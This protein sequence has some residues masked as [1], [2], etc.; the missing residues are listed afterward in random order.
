MWPFPPRQKA[1]PA[2]FETVTATNPGGAAVNWLV[3]KSAPGGAGCGCGNAGVAT[4]VTSGGGATRWVRGE[5]SRGSSRAAASPGGAFPGPRG[6]G[7][8]GDGVRRQRL[9][10]RSAPGG[11][12]AGAVAIGEAP[13]LSSA[14]NT[15]FTYGAA[16]T[17]TVAA[18][19]VP[20]PSLSAAGALPSGLTFTDNGDG[21]GTLG[22]T[23]SAAGSFP[24][25]ITAH[26]GY[27]ADATQSFTLTV[28]AAST[29]TA[30]TS[31]VNPSVFGQSVTF[32][33]TVTDTSAGSAAM[34]TGSVQFV[35]DSVNFGSLVAVTGASSNSSTATSQATASLSVAGSPHA[36]TAIY[37]NADGNFSTSPG[38]LNG[39]Q[40][41]GKA[42]STTAVTSSQ[43]A[44]VFGQSVTFTAT[45]SAVAPGAG[46]PTGTVTFL[47]GGS[48]I[49]TGTL[50]G[51]VATF[52]TSAL[53]VGSQAI[54][55]SYGG[56]GNFNDGTGTLT[57]NPQ[58]VSK[59][60]STTV[61]TS[62]QNP[63]VFGQ[64]VTF[65]AT[66]AAVAPGAGTP[67]G[68][69]TFLDGGSS[70]G[71][72][73]LSAGVAT[74]ATSALAMGS[75]TITTSYGG[76]GN[77]NVGTG[78]LT[79]NPQVVNKANSTT[80]LISS[81]NPSMLAQ[82]VTFTATVSMVAPGAGTP[83]GTVT[84]L[85]GG[86]AIG[87]GTLSGGVATFGT[88]AL[89][90][91]NHTIT[92][93]YSADTKCNRSTGPLTGNPQVVVA[94]P[95]IA[96]AFNPVTIPVKS[97]TSLG[98]T[99]TNPAANTMALAGVAFA[100][101]LP[102]GLTVASGSAT[103]CGGTL[104]TTAP[105]SIA[106]SGAAIAV[107]SN[108]AFSVTVTGPQPGQ[109]TNTTGAVSSTNGGTGNTASA[110]LVVGGVAVSPASINFG[111]VN[112]GSKKSAQ[113]TI[114]NPGTAAASLSISITPGAGASAGNFSVRNNCPSSL[115]PGKSCTVQ[116]TFSAPQV[117]NS[118]QLGESTAALI[119]TSGATSQQVTLQAIVVD[120]QPSFRPPML[121]F[122]Q[123]KV[124]TS[125]TE[126]L[127]L[128]SSGLT[129]LKI[130]GFSFSG[131]DP[132]DFGQTNNCGPALA[133]RTSCQIQ[134]TFTPS[135]RGN[136]TASLTLTSNVGTLSAQLAGA[137]Q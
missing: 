52:T 55:A 14:S 58:V 105:T 117:G 87:T 89:A 19:G 135:A 88:S 123:K 20:T 128:S 115:G 71:T 64:S 29:T 131:N 41:V 129:S 61:V 98:F 45:V 66:V 53:A 42:N 118:S 8:D 5:A 18:S 32:T 106:L 78:T 43:N 63:S 82:S 80:A 22:G 49:G 92:A 4:F 137:G 100:D 33:A 86:S 133:P 104:T 132:S 26:N 127:L 85:D 27:G 81:Q 72:G 57:T 35:I 119:V 103:V 102:S 47:D 91:G 97:T 76:D 70:I 24:L 12:R 16:G 60:T 2:G 36:V 9:R 90:A 37:V 125:S 39:G 11:E 84:F 15:T 95:S 111:D 109:F 23:P 107:G 46:T 126:T 101:T 74:F 38:T 17:F 68:T 65:S 110:K 10:P 31:S 1:R 62:S 136:R 121:V 122:G 94:P 48:S 75:H 40:G 108:C 6:R 69:V 112:S 130:D 120:V 73:T 7:V 67:T 28:N 134:V 13:S 34:P 54:T 93:S 83:T 59:A 77:F 21:T 50:S 96:K 25:S 114:D 56:D 113:V 30:V 79:G 51:G 116:V 124:K 3:D 44:S 99:I